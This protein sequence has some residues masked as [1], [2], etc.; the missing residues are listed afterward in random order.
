[1][2]QRIQSLFLL[3]SIIVVSINHFIPFFTIDANFGDYQILMD[4][5]IVKVNSSVEE[6]DKGLNSQWIFTSV[7]HFIFILGVL[8]QI[9]QF[10]NRKNQLKIGRAMMMLGILYI[11]VAIIMMLNFSSTLSASISKIY[12]LL[13]PILG[14]ILVLL[15]NIYIQKDENLIR[16]IDRIR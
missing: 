16:S 15:A 11:G 10:K 13:F 9:F 7:L 5:Y 4:F 8:I 1:M 14:V 6:L 2:I 12:G 3:F